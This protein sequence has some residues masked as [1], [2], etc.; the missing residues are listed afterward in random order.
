MTISA[1]RLQLTVRECKLPRPLASTSKNRGASPILF[2]FSRRREKEVGYP[3]EKGLE[4]PYVAAIIL[5]DTASD[6]A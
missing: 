6:T 4:I 5:F 3:P 2:L 1:L